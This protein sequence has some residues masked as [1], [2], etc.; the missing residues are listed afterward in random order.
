MNPREQQPAK[1]STLKASVRE[2]L[3]KNF[4][5]ARPAKKASDWEKQ[6]HP[7]PPGVTRHQRSNTT[8]DGPINLIDARKTGQQGEGQHAPPDSNQM[9]QIVPSPYHS[10]LPNI[11]KSGG[12]DPLLGVDQQFLHAT[13][14]SQEVMNQQPGTTKSPQVRKGFGVANKTL[15]ALIVIDQPVKVKLGRNLADSSFKASS[16]LGHALNQTLDTIGH[17]DS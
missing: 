6:F 15:Q 1:K 9:H 8:H 12:Q 7:L 16:T 5:T 14:H 4:S 3:A 13:S 10:Y 11:F 17:H 2:Q